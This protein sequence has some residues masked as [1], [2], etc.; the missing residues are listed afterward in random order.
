MALVSLCALVGALA[1]S[2]APAL[3]VAPEAPGVSV[4]TPV[5]ATE[6][7]LY[8]VVNPLA[9]MFPV[10]AGTYQFVYR[11]SSK[12]ED[13]CKGAGEVLVP[14]SAGMYFGLGAES[15]SETVTGLTADTE[16]AVCLVAEDKEGKT[17]S[18]AVPFKTALPPETPEKL[19]AKPIAATTA[20]LSGVLNPKAEGNP[21]TYEFLYSQSATECEGGTITPAEHATGAKLEAAAAKVTS[22]LPHTAYTFCLRAHNEASE[23][24]ALSSPPVTFTTLA[25]PPTIGE[26]FSTDVT[27]TSATLRAQ[28][29]PQGATTSYTFEYAPVGGEFKP[30][31]EPEGS[32][33][34]PEGDT[35]VALSV[36]VQQ[37]LLADTTYEFRLL[38]SNSAQQDVTGEPVSFTTQHATILSALPDGRQYEMV[39]PPEKQG[40]L[41]YGPNAGWEEPAAMRDF[42]SKASADGDAITDFANVPTEANPQGFA[43]KVSILSTRGPSGWS[44]EV[45]ALPHKGATGP[46]EISKGSSTE[47]TLFSEDLSHGAVMQSGPFGALSPE[48]TEFTPYLRTYYLNGNVEEHCHASCYRPLVTTADTAEGVKFGGPYGSQYINECELVICGPIAV[49]ATPDASHIVLR[50]QVAL[51]STPNEPSESVVYNQLDPPFLYEWSDGQLQPLYQLPEGE[52]GAGVAGGQLSTVANQLSDNGSVFFSHDGHLYLH[53]FTKDE[54][55]RL[56]VAQEHT[57]PTRDEAEFLYASSDGSTVLFTDPQQLTTAAGG[58]IYECRIVES[59]GGVSCELELTGLASD[60]LIGGSKDASYLY[61]LN[62]EDKLM[63]D[64][65]SGGGWTTAE[66]PFVGAQLFS[67]RTRERNFPQPVPSAVPTYR[68]SP[69]GVYL[70]FMS[71][72]SLTGYD[73]RDAVS[74]MPDFEV[75]LYDADS[76]RLICASCDPTGARPVGVEYKETEQLVAGE[77]STSDHPWVAANLPPWLRTDSQE[78]GESTYQPRYLSDSGRLFFDSDDALVPQDVNGTQDVYEYEPAG[79]GSCTTGNVTFGERSDGCVDLISSGTSSE[80]SAFMDASATGG[81]VFFITAAKLV[82]ADRDTARDVYDAHECTSASPCTQ[83]PAAPPPCT[84]E[85]S[86]KPPPTAQPSVYGLPSSAT[87]SG[88]G[89]I[90]PA[91]TPPAAK[92]KAKVVKCKRGVTK[93]KSQCVKSKKKTKRSNRRAHR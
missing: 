39:T 80:E 69:N 36:H 16:Y 66:G 30:V 21:G 42:I 9:V 2:S 76:N 17:P 7:V 27:A 55:F 1:F 4:E 3:A 62:G 82:P 59:A 60:S 83:A 68:V 26:T 81:D 34:L 64:H 31:P 84:T 67:G 19:E 29:N 6:A 22:L 5:H 20:T 72:E 12:A 43:S 85:A 75:Y 35:G 54:S 49:D 11:P 41:F 86:C 37:G 87:F 44:S 53:D 65:Y 63:V 93:K 70:A 92:P 52:G 8:G 48:A 78:N 38:A 46:Q 15:F 24:S 45:I 25:A 77:F 33:S 89:N 50:S 32:G 58:G 13:E 18:P 91:P 56:D 73:T 71:S 28:V 79:V 90:A 10:E 57:E 51:T 14:A 61:F 40:A 23:E 74:E 47:N 88:P